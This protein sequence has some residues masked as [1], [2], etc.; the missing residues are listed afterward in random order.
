MNLEAFFTLHSDLPRQGPG[1]DAST[2]EAINCLPGLPESPRVLDLGCGPG[3]QTLVLARTLKVPVVAID[4]HQPFLDQLTLAAGKAGLADYVQTRR[5]S[6]DALD[7]P[8]ESID[9]I[10]SEGAAYIIGLSKALRLWRPL[11]RTGGLLA[12]TE[13]TWLTDNPPVE[14]AAFWENAYPDITTIAENLR[15]AEAEKYEV[16]DTFPL[17][18]EDWW[19]EYYAPLQKRITALRSAAAAWPE[20]AAVIAETEQ[21]INM[22]AR[23]SDSYG[24]VFYILRKP[25]NSAL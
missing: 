21:E 13:A 18:A 7:Y 14:A 11:L 24:Y 16:I 1:S 9:L 2:L 4:V 22:F 19:A 12:F 3:R 8:A 6:M 23:F 15:K 25:A 5:I 20:L 10:W 17:P